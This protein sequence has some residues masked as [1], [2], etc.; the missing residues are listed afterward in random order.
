[1]MK[2]NFGNRKTHLFAIASFARQNN[3][4]HASVL[5]QALEQNVLID[6]HKNFR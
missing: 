4:D 1:M 6:A 3:L 2:I 5:E